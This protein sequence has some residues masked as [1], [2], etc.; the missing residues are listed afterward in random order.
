MKIT[1]Y[2]NQLRLSII[3]VFFIYFLLGL[4]VYWHGIKNPWINSNTLETIF[5]VP[6]K[7]HWNELSCLFSNK[8]HEVFLEAEYHPLPSFLYVLNGKLGGDNP[9]FIRFLY[10]VLISACSTL[11]YVTGKHLVKFHRW[12]FIG[13]F[14]YLTH[15]INIE[16]LQALDSGSDVLT[17]LFLLSAL[18][19]HLRMRKQELKEGWIIAESIFYIFALFSRESAIVFPALVFLY[20]LLFSKY[21]KL[22]G[23]TS[24][25]FP[26]EY[27]W[28]VIISLGY[29]LLNFYVINNGSVPLSSNHYSLWNIAESLYNIFAALRYIAI[30]SYSIYS[31]PPY[32][33]FTTVFVFMVIYK[34]ASLKFPKET[35]IFCLA[36]ILINLIIFVN[37]IP[38]KQLSDYLRANQ[39]NGIWIRLEYLFLAYIGFC[40]LLIILLESVSFCSNNA[41]KWGIRIIIAFYL[42]AGV[43]ILGTSVFNNPN[44]ITSNFSL[45]FARSRVVD[46]SF[47]GELFSVGVLSSLYFIKTQNPPILDEIRGGLRKDFKDSQ[48]DKILE[49]FGD[50]KIYYKIKKWESYLTLR[51][52]RTAESFYREFEKFYKNR[53]NPDF[54]YHECKSS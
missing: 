25:F 30:P 23:K 39:V 13:G 8:Y 15:P 36:W 12:A 46:Y 37:I 6:A 3:F 18:L 21:R 2:S 48:I 43:N 47:Q 10:I 26:K 51:N 27:F 35:I 31:L 20:D 50:G 24:A 49:Y 19:V 44:N 17:S 38:V 32:L 29:I 42:F 45:I 11:I 41:F 53:N 14:M 40:W 5:F 9:Y 4:I 28:L 54:H 52:I 34:I 16:P 33:I 22:Y 1:N 7:I